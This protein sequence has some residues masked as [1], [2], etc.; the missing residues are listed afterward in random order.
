MNILVIGESCIDRYVYGDCKRLSPEGPVPVFSPLE[1]VEQKGMAANTFCNLENMLTPPDAVKLVTNFQSFHHKNR[2]TR[3]IDNKTNQIL[4]RIDENDE[5]DNIGRLMDRVESLSR[6]G[7]KIEKCEVAVVSDYCKGFLDNKDL[8]NIGNMFEF[9]ILDT[10]RLLTQNVLDAYN[11]VKL[12][13]SEFEKNRTVLHNLDPKNNLNKCIVTLGVKGV[14]FLNDVF[15]PPKAIQ[16]FDVSGAGDVFTAAFSCM[17][18]KNYSV[19]DGIKFAQECCSK[20]IQKR[21]TC[22]YEKDMD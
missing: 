1:T 4:L 9:S 22:I 2:K 17:V 18:A 6:G 5:C 3:Y 12:N 13:E 20:V 19:Q 14:K 16:T 10:K 15:T 7:Y 21:G 11:F 8:V